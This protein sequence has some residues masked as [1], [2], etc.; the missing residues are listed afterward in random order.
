MTFVMLSRILPGSV[1]SSEEFKKTAAKVRKMIEDEVHE[2]RWVGS[3]SL[4]GNYDVLDIFEVPTV[5]H[6]ATISAIVRFHGKAETET[7]LA[8]DWTSFVAK[9]GKAKH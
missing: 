5:Q 3:Y 8:E 7:M 4:M 1:S 9:A 6:A 2:A